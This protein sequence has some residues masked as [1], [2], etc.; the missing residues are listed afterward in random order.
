LHLD[1]DKIILFDGGNDE[2]S[3]SLDG[4]PWFNYFWFHDTACLEVLFGIKGDIEEWMVDSYFD[5]VV[6]VFIVCGKTGILGI[7]T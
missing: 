1:C 6:L 3:G 7:I 2:F 5:V 4:L